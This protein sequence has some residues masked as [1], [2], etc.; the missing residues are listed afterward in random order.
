[1]YRSEPNFMNT[2]FL[3][4]RS[5]LA[6][7]GVFFALSCKPQQKAQAP[8]AHAAAAVSA[9]SNAPAAPPKP[10]AITEV[11][12]ING[13]GN[14]S[15]NY[16][17]HLL[18][19]KHLRDVLLQ[20]GIA[21]DHISI[22]ASDGPDT[23]AD[24]SVRDVQPE[25]D[26]WRL[27]GTRFE[28]RLRTPTTLVN[29]ALQGA[30]LQ[31]ATQEQ[32]TAWFAAAKDRLHPGDTLLLYVTD[33]GTR[34]GPDPM[35]N[36]IMLWGQNAFISVRELSALI[37]TLDPGV[38]VVNLMSQCYSGGFAGLMSARGQDQEPAGNVCGYFSSTADRKA[39]GCFAEN[40]G[41]DNVGHSFE[42]MRALGHVRGFNDAHQAVLVG[43]ATP[44]VPLR[45]SDVY[46][47]SVLNK[48][49]AASKMTLDVLV[50]QVLRQ[51]FADA[52]KWE[53]EVRLLDSIA[54][55]YGS[56]SPRSLSELNDLATR[57]PVIDQ[58]LTNVKNAWGSALDDANE[59]N[60]ERFLAQ[61]ADWQARLSDPALGALDGPGTRALTG[62]LLTS[63]GQFSATDSA[64]EARLQALQTR[65]N[66]AEDASYRME[67]RLAVV[68]R[69]RTILISIAGRFY[70]G[71]AG[72]PQQKAAYAGLTA[73]EGFSLPLPPAA[74][75]PVEPAPQAYPPFDQDIALTQG[76][77]P[78]WIGISFKEPDE[79]TT[80]KHPLPAGASMVSVVYP[81]SPA[82]TA[83]FAP[84][85][86]VLGP[87]G[88]PF[89]S[90]NQIRSWV[91]LTPVGQPG[92]LS[93][94]RDGKHKD[95]TIVP[96]PFPVKW[97]D[98]P[99]PVQMGGVAPKVTV[100]G[101]RGPVDTILSKHKKHL[102]YFWAT[103]CGPC[104]LSVPELLALEKQ[105][106]IP[107]VAVTDEND[108]VLDAFFKKFTNPFPKTV[109]MDAGRRTFVAYGVAGTPTFVLVDEHNAVQWYQVGYN[110]NAGL[111]VPGWKWVH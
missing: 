28:F 50:D 19:L 92:T 67:V 84:G 27:E 66:A 93:I 36:R 74:N 101:Y 105:M 82:L 6:L 4:F 37:A 38:R 104:K 55:A 79:E 20:G 69:L 12:M 1:M 5:T 18:H 51:A 33:H 43:D 17:S 97:P 81:N 34:N 89:T 96:A 40:L 46:L 52:G 98:L 3:R 42:F 9:A 106:K 91:M 73:C 111:S 65:G 15:L 109:A 75:A 90:K 11:L 107:V 108:K 72:T 59:S 57:L 83:G 76:A 53:K 23:A 7:I 87:P 21:P 71:G 60:L 95:L 49:A 2:R 14:P 88:S 16:Q 32:L 56:F 25:A 48:A 47:E 61:R 80:K 54:R 85:D 35:D 13:A 26:F 29:S 68:L 8:A 70:V 99:G 45:T 58:Q 63:F 62:E 31:P 22:L 10:K 24:L 100:K 110:P 44:D 94:L 39:Y 30:T 78:G 103:W 102:L 41:K 77:L 86:I 64:T